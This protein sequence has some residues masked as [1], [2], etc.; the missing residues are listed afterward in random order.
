MAVIVRIFK[1]KRHDLGAAAPFSTTTSSLQGRTGGLVFAPKLVELVAGINPAS[2]KAISV[3]RLYCFGD[4]LRALAS[5]HVC[6]P[7][8]Y[9]GKT[10]LPRVLR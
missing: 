5:L 3:H 10:W 1:S 9:H 6:L 2:R 8:C 4:A 7:V